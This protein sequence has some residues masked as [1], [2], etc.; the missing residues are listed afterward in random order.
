MFISYIK[1]HVKKLPGTPIEKKTISQITNIDADGTTTLS[2]IDHLGETNGPEIFL[3][4]DQIIKTMNVKT[5][6]PPKI[7]D[8]QKADPKS[9]GK[10]NEQVHKGMIV[11]ALQHNYDNY[12]TPDGLDITSKVYATKEFKKG[13]C[14]LAL[15]TGII[16]KGNE[17]TP[18]L[19]QVCIDSDEYVIAKPSAA[20]YVAPY[21]HVTKLPDKKAANMELDIKEV[22]VIVGVA[23]NAKE[24]NV[25]IPLL[26][27]S[28]KLSKGTE[29]V[30][31]LPEELQKESKKRAFCEI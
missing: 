4:A 13:M 22:P 16:K 29:L 23:P 8:L 6:K 21:F 5:Y 30:V 11:A 26:T 9:C 17:T 24:F 28:K 3:T 10:L 1:H 2:K 31:H 18:M 27:N 12:P 14:T 25:K 19:S 20:D 15:V 7:V